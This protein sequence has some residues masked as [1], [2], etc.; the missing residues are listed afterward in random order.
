MHIILYILK[1]IALK[2]NIKKLIDT[3]YFIALQLRAMLLQLIFFLNNILRYVVVN[4]AINQFLL[5]KV[6]MPYDI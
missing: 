2:N 1:K 6:K 4:K 3:C 5:S